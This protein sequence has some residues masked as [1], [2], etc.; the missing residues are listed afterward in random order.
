MFVSIWALNDQIKWYNNCTTYIYVVSLEGCCNDLC[1]QEANLGPCEF[2]TFP[3]HWH[4]NQLLL[5]LGYS[6]GFFDILQILSIMFENNMYSIINSNVFGVM[7][8][9]KIIFAIGVERFYNCKHAVE[10]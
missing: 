2:C 9:K 5:S 1:M 8:G 4:P 6:N 10:E 3:S 7:V